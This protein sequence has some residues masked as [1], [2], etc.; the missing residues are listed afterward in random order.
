[1]ARSA[2]CSS[3][4]SWKNGKSSKPTKNAVNS[5]SGSGTDEMTTCATPDISSKKVSTRGSLTLTGGSRNSRAAGGR[6]A[7]GFGSF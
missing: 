3:P 7:V 2:T 5:S 6:I 4:K 1:M